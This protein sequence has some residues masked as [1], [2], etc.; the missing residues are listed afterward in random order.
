MESISD[1]EARYADIY[2][3]L[4]LVNTYLIVDQFMTIN[5][6]HN[7]ILSNNFSKHAK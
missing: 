5:E 7:M 4:C 2:I 6:Y 3:A 1:V